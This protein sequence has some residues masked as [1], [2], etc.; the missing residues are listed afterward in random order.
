MS[1]TIDVYR[2]NYFH[3][4][5]IIDF[6]AFVSFFSSIGSRSIE[7]SNLLLVYKARKF[8]KGMAVDG[9][10]QILWGLFKSYILAVTLC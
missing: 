6:F 3:Y 10:R 2:N 5:K 4:S 9:L 1:Y 8:D 7:E